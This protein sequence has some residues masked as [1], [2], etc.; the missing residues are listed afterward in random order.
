L[1]GGITWVTLFAFVGYFFGNIPF[2]KHNFSL[3]I[4]AIILISIIPM[5]VEAWKAYREKRM[6]T[7]NRKD[8]T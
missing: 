8:L 4:M 1:V 3:V 6:N 2:I 5:L 7:E